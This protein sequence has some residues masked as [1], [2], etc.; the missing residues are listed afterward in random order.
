MKLKSIFQNR[1]VLGI[2]IIVL[3]AFIC[4]VLAPVINSAATKD[5]TVI[6]AVAEIK[7]GSQITKE[8]VQEIRMS[9]TNQPADIIKKQEDVIGKY[10]AMDMIVGD[11]VLTQKIS[12]TPEVESSYLSGLNGKERAISITLNDLA[13]GVSGKL[14]PGDIVSIIVP[15]YR[16]SGTTAIPRELQYVKV[17]AVTAKSG[18]DTDKAPA[19]GEEQELPSTVTVLANEQQSKLLAEIEAD[20]KAHLSLVYRGGKETAEQFLKAQ[21]EILNPAPESEAANGQPG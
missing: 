5:V 1:M 13:N 21:S 3:S 19:E 7:S 8:M 2:T 18:A 14:R 12:E 9:N 4:F 16:K 6:R 20:N 10:A 11:Y 15:N 17:I